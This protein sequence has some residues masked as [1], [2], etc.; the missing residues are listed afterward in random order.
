MNGTDI[1]DLL[2]FIQCLE[3]HRIFYELHKYTHR[4]IMVNVT[5]P[6][7]RWEVEFGEDGDMAVEKFVTTGGVGDR[8]RLTELFTRFSE[9]PDGSTNDGHS[10]PSDTLK[11]CDFTPVN[12]NEI[13]RLR[14]EVEALKAQAERLEQI[15]TAQSD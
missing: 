7:E 10:S 13:A 4:R 11:N 14:L 6:G 3:E 1:S 5:V 12:D 2:D 9:P 8:E 15:L